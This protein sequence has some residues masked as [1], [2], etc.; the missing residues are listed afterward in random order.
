MATSLIAQI[1][2]TGVTRL[3]VSEDATSA[4]HSGQTASMYC[5]LNIWPQVHGGFSD[6]RPSTQILMHDDLY[7]ST[8]G[9][10]R[11]GRTLICR[12]YWAML[13]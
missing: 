3:P 10:W 6:V 7:A 13:R 2:E 8:M 1:D 5:I 12:A 4:I 9:Q 11:R